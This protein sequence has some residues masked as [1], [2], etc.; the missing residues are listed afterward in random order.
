LQNGAGG[1]KNEEKKV[2]SIPKGWGREKSCSGKEREQRVIAILPR[3]HSQKFLG[4][5]KAVSG[6][7]VRRRLEKITEKKRE[8]MFV[9]E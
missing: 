6:G 3:E 7:K 9:L 5:V 1:K 2:G 4:S 8:E